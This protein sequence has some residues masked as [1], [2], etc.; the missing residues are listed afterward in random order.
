MIFGASRFPHTRCM[1]AQAE[2]WTGD[3][4]E[5]GQQLLAAARTSGSA[6]T[7]RF[8]ATFLGHR[9]EAIANL[10]VLLWAVT[11]GVLRAGRRGRNRSDADIEQLADLAASTADPDLFDDSRGRANLHAA[12]QGVAAVPDLP[13]NLAINL[14]DLYTVTACCNAAIDRRMR[15]S[16]VLSDSWQKRY[17]IYSNVLRAQVRRQ[18]RKRQT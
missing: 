10:H 4:V 1:R 14:T 6:F 2:R 15:D 18:D 13:T 3:E 9:P 8:N 17:R 16:T 12:Q 5:L 11:A 7:E